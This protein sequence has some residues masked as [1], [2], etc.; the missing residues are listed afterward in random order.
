MT[1]LSKVVFSGII[2]ILLLAFFHSDTKALEGRAGEI[3][4]TK[5]Q[6]NELRD[7]G[8]LG[9][10]QVLSYGEH[11][12]LGY[13]IPIVE[14]TD[15]G[16]EVTTSRTYWK[17]SEMNRG[18]TTI[19]ATG[20]MTNYAGAGR[21]FP[22]M[23]PED[24]QAGIKAAYNYDFRH[25]GDDLFFK[26]V[27][28]LT[29]SK[30]NI[31]KLAGE[32][33]RI[34]SNYRTD[35]EPKPSLFTD[36]DLDVWYRE[37]I[38][39]SEPFASKNLGQLQIKYKDRSRVNDVWVWV[40]G[41]R[42]ITRVGAGNRCDC[43]GGFV[44]NMDESWTWD[45]DTSKF[46][47]KLLEVKEHLV[48]SIRDIE[49]V[50]RGETYLEGAHINKPILERRKVWLIE[51]TPQDPN[52][53]TSKR[54]YYIDP[55]SWYTGW[56]EV[57][58]RAGGLWKGTCI[59]WTLLDNPEN[60]GGGGTLMYSAGSSHDYKIWEGAPDHMREKLLNNTRMEPNLFTLDAMRRRGR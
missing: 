23:S 55:E 37:I 16:P 56:V 20:E 1:K 21:P 34:Y 45:G 33:W 52:Y 36:R 50:L 42:R 59:A 58:D 57:Y 17:M 19:S 48:D 44:N 49:S 40:P 41:L 22:D 10:G 32:T 43:L 54:L 2:S 53:C 28:Y 6:L 27:Y 4:E 25:F 13:A 24:P 14:T 12:D 39:F 11:I 31:R 35:L 30:R 26:W 47:W 8:L 46:N 9:A 29:D 3:I 51:Q 18:R 15:R 38:V 7:K 60:A 5:E